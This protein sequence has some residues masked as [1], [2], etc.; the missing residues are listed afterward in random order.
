[1][2]L[3]RISLTRLTNA[4]MIPY[5]S[6]DIDGMCESILK[7]NPF[8]KLRVVLK[9]RGLSCHLWK[10]GLHVHMIPMLEILMM[11]WSLIYFIQLRMTCH[12][13]LMVT[14]NHPLGVV[15]CIPLRICIFS[16]NI[17]N[18]ICAQILTDTRK[19]SSQ[20]SQRLTLHRNNFFC[21]KAFW[22][23]MKMKG[24]LFFNKRISFS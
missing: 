8:M 18:H 4:S 10:N 2:I 12:R 16:M 1:M 11:I 5:R 14:F 19:R 17:S 7:K 20:R 9:K 15:I 24:K 3:W 21:P 23:D 22:E 6:G 13:T